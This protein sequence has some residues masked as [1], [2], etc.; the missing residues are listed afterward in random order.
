MS[1]PRSIP[2]PSYPIRHGRPLHNRSAF[3]AV[4]EPE[5]L[6]AVEASRKGKRKRAGSSARHTPSSKE[7]DWSWYQIFM[8]VSAI[9]FVIVDARD[10]SRMAD[11]LRDQGVVDLEAFLSEKPEE[12]AASNNA[13]VLD[14]N[15][16]AVRMFGGTDRA[17]FLGEPTHRFFDPLCPV[18]QNI[19]AAYL[20]GEREYQEHARTV[21]LDGTSFDT[22]L[23]TVMRVPSGTPGIWL[24]AFI[25][26]TDELKRRAALDGLREELAHFSRISMLGE[27]SASIAHEL[28]QPLST[29]AISALAA[30]RFLERAE[31]DVAAARHIIARISSQ[32]GRARDVMERIRSMAA[33]RATNE[34]LVPVVDLAREAMLFVRHEL[35]RGQVSWSVDIPDKNQRIRVDQIQIQQVIVN[36]LMNAVQIIKDNRTQNPR[37]DM[38]GYCAGARFILEIG[39]NGP[40]MPGDVIPRIFDSFHTSRE[41][42]L[43]LGLSICKTIVEAHGGTIHAGNRTGRPGAVFT[44]NLPL[45]LAD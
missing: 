38:A 33:R 41:D 1:L 9:A 45:P 4:A 44:V 5:P 30:D 18:L 22:I 23:A 31:P 26:I 20:A 43:G 2:A 19:A 37:I 11:R 13:F 27:M 40:G 10:R 8:Q 34:V 6:D 12:F 7:T 21:R 39:D 35:E 14:L 28:G 17:Q 36:L 24:A 25:D 42:G 32:A 15:E 3:T 29:I 16:A